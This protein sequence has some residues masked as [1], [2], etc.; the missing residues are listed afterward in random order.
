MIFEFKSWLK[1]RLNQNLWNHTKLIDYLTTVRLDWYNSTSVLANFASTQ[2]PNPGIGK[3][4]TV[5]WP[6]KV[7][8]RFSF[9]F[10]VE[11][12]SFNR[13]NND[14][15]YT[16]LVKSG[17]ILVGDCWGPVYHCFIFLLITKL[18]AKVLGYRWYWIY[19]QIFR[20]SYSRQTA[21][22]ES[23]VRSWTY[24]FIYFSC[25]EPIIHVW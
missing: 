14:F 25:L 3:T 7:K 15:H 22:A 16:P 4:Q 1:L 18:L 17:E 2:S 10:S 9:T 13:T 8:G 6:L 24:S 11:F 20:E 23:V 21:R 19:W 12:R 5:R